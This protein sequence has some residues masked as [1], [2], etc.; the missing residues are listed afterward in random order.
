MLTDPER[1]TLKAFGQASLGNLAGFVISTLFYGIFVLLF[2]LSTASIHCQRVRSRATWTMFGTTV[3]SFVLATLQWTTSFTQSTMQFRWRLLNL[4]VDPQ[5]FNRIYL[6]GGTG[7]FTGNQV[8]NWLLLAVQL[9]TD[10]VVIWRA[11][12]LC[13][14]RRWLIIPPLVFLLG[15]AVT[16]FAFLGLDSKT[17]GTLVYSTEERAKG[18]LLN[19]TG[20]LSMATNLCSTLLIAYML[21]LC[22][23]TWNMCTEGGWSQAQEVLLII[24]ESGAVYSVLQLIVVLTLNEQT[25]FGTPLSYFRTA[26]W[27]AYVQA[28]AMYPTTV[29]LLSKQKR[30]LSNVHYFDASSLRSGS[31]S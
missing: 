30:S 27:K 15:T 19:T 2:S 1:A 12:V 14:R 20:T 7:F 28:T 9:V 6:T 11:W 21:W 23:K 17:H 8:E 31:P 29:L 24:I 5:A 4:L 10:C 3:L 25:E 18:A 13:T 26:V 16:S 22:R